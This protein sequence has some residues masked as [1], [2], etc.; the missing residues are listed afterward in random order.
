MSIKLPSS[1]VISGSVLTA[2]DVPVN[3]L[4]LRLKTITPDAATLNSVQEGGTPLESTTSATGGF[5]FAIKDSSIIAQLI[6]Q[7]FA[8]LF[9]SADDDLTATPD[10][11]LSRSTPLFLG[12]HR[13][14][15]VVL[16]WAPKVAGDMTKPAIAA[17]LRVRSV[18]RDGQRQAGPLVLR[19]QLV[20]PQDVPLKD[21]TV[22]AQW[23][24]PETGQ[25]LTFP[26]PAL[27]DEPTATA[28]TAAD[29]R[30]EIQVPRG[31]DLL[32]FQ[33]YSQYA[34][35]FSVQP[36]RST[37]GPPVAEIIAPE[38]SHI[39]PTE[40]TAV[41]LRLD[42]TDPAKPSLCV[43]CV[44]RNGKAC[45][46]AQG[47]LE[48][49]GQLLDSSG[50]RALAGHRV[51]VKAG[52]STRVLA[53]V[54][55]NAQG[56][57]ALPH[58]WPLDTPAS[59]VS[60]AW[61]LRVLDPGGVELAADAAAAQDGLVDAAVPLKVTLATLADRSPTVA[62]LLSEL[63]K[64]LDAKTQAALTAAKIVTLQDIA[65]A[66]GIRLLS[67]IEK[68]DAATI[69]QLEQAAELL[70]VMPASISATDAVK[71]LVAWQSKGVTGTAAIGTLSRAHGTKA[72]TT[73]LGDFRA[74][75]AT[76]RSSREK[77][78][79]Q[80]TPAQRSRASTEQRG[81]D[82]AHRAVLLNTG[83]LSGDQL[84]L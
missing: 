6:R 78:S 10:A 41:K 35:R 4:K 24:V 56:Y 27:P 53:D 73:E 74:A 51:Q 17:K 57:F 81:G 71:Y 22:R 38:L 40:S 13:T 80:S 31:G 62:Q 61:K 26:Q 68:A 46:P 30:F 37:G 5:S 3:A 8:L 50:T 67:G 1:L 75:Q 39:A 21:A 29:G 82:D 66:G 64:I 36:A 12:A 44:H 69:A 23:V 16:E 34:L 58:P 54:R 15:G 63:K 2:N 28:S 77:Q 65:Q 60:M 79:T 76:S 20:G 11:G 18:D 48:A 70:G 14:V 59:D 49:L 43:P 45:R 25:T 19:G 72:L 33:P 32:P 9:K 42:Q 7:G 83:C 47:S 84:R 52:T 55:T